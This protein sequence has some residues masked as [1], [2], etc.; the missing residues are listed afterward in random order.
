MIDKASGQTQP[1]FG[2][3]LWGGWVRRRRPSLKRARTDPDNPRDATGR[4]A[5]DVQHPTRDLLCGALVSDGLALGE[6]AQRVSH[7][8]QGDAEAATLL[9]R[10]GGVQ[11]VACGKGGPLERDHEIWIERRDLCVAEMLDACRHVP[12]EAAY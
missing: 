1:R 4:Y 2:G 12:D 8:L 5:Q 7:L 3:I 10:I 6:V 9:C 11:R